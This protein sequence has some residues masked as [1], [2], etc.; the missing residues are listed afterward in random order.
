MSSIFGITCTPFRYPLC[1]LESG[2]HSPGRMPSFE[3]K[4]SRGC[5]DGMPGEQSGPRAGPISR[6][7]E[8]PETGGPSS[9]RCPW[10]EMHSNHCYPC[11]KRRQGGHRHHMACQASLVLQ[12]PLPAWL[13]EGI[14]LVITLSTQRYVK[15]VGMYGM[16]AFGS[17]PQ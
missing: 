10:R 3:L 5:H 2:P 8:G 6:V 7:S 9:R 16:N 12:A 17:D 11:N 4:L 15:E 1:F 14:L 13:Y